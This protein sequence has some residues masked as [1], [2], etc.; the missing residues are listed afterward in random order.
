MTWDDVGRD[1]P[2]PVGQTGEFQ[3]LSGQSRK[4]E[5][6]HASQ[7]NPLPGARGRRESDSDLCRL[8]TGAFNSQALSP[9][10]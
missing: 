1:G 9:G 10:A 2:N 6:Y 4:K 8:L 5:L 7:Q 3:E